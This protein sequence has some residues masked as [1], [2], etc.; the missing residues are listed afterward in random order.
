MDGKKVLALEAVA[1]MLL[2][3]LVVTSARQPLA[4]LSL[5]A[6]KRPVPKSELVCCDSCDCPKE[7]S[8][9]CDDTMDGD[10]ADGCLTCT[11]ADIG[12]G[13]RCLDKLS[14]CPDACNWDY[15]ADSYSPARNKPGRASY[16]H[17]KSSN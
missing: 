3:S 7:G 8:C 14:T 16:N 1:L 17:G 11:C 6:G 12:Q 13:C 10:C 4:G 5:L 9:I 2:T 15:I